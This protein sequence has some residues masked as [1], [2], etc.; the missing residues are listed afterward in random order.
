MNPREPIETLIERS[1]LGTE[2][3]RRLRSRTAPEDVRTILERAQGRRDAS[4]GTSSRY[5]AALAYARLGIPVVPLH[6]VVRSGRSA[7]VACSCGEPTCTRVGAHPLPSHGVADATT[8]P[9]RL[10]WWWRRF[11]EANVGLATGASFDALVVRGSVGDT[12]RWSVIAEA[13][14]AGG[15]LVRTGGDTWC[16]LFAPAGLH[17][18]R[19]WGLAR[20]EWRGWGGWVVAPPSHHPGGAVAAWVRDLETPLPVMPVAIRERL[21]PDVAEEGGKAGHGWLNEELREARITPP[22]L[23]RVKLGKA[24]GLVAGDVVGTRDVRLTASDQLLEDDLSTQ[25]LQDELSN[26]LRVVE[27]DLAKATV[28]WLEDQA[29]KARQRSDSSEES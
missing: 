19:P 13:L 7:G 2:G 29:E 21:E 10:T 22:G 12:A 1:S 24:I 8:D 16:F 20:V 4:Q 3:A 26:L 11:P 6:Y 27:Q 28:E 9:I 14:R 15:P 18:Q 5:L 25:Q 17:S 23:S